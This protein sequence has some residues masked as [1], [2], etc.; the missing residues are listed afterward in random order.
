M[1]RGKLIRWGAVAL[2]AA[3]IFGASSIQ[4]SNLPS[5][6]SVPAHFA[7]YLILAVLL[8]TALRP[9]R[10]RA[11]AAL[12]ALSMASLY[13]MSDELHQYFTPGRVP[14]PMDWLTDTLGA[15]AGVLAACVVEPLLAK[16][17]AKRKRETQ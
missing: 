16:W 5:G 9:G 3:A 14:D 15:S 11:S 2:W 10:S 12:L 1:T 6:Y 17:R 7:E 13:G 4:G 8:Y